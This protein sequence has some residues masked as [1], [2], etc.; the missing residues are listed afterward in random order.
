L[1][2]ICLSSAI[3][4]KLVQRNAINKGEEVGRR[5]RRRTRKREKTEEEEGN[6]KHCY[7]S[8]CRGNDTHQTYVNNQSQQS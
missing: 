7:N 3:I 6:Q 2:L 4:T 8:D 1:V 5:E